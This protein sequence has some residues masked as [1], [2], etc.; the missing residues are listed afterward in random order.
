ME[1]VTLGWLRRLLC[2][3]CPEL[4]PAR[5]LASLQSGCSGPQH[6]QAEAAGPRQ[7]GDLCFL[8]SPGVLD[9]HYPVCAAWLK[10][11]PPLLIADSLT[12][13]RAD[14]VRAD[15]GNTLNVAALWTRSGFYPLRE[16]CSGCGWCQRRNL[17]TST[18]WAYS[19]SSTPRG[20]ARVSPLHLEFRMNPLR[21]NLWI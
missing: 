2:K 4:T 21:F 16:D 12:T 17:T 3:E 10:I 9:L 6:Y 7:P 20:D 14:T 11:K 19:R 5:L 1:N 15:F 18:H 8:L 13:D